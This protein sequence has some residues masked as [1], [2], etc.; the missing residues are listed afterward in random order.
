LR[1]IA[2]ELGIHHTTVGRRVKA[3]ERQALGV[4]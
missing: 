2:A 4:R 3:R 1:E